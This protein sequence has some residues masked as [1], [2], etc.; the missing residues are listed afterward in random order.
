M[1]HE[2]R[3]I[4]SRLE[5]WGRWA[6]A[7][8]GPRVAACMTGV[9]CDAMQ[10]A[11]QGAP[12]PK[13]GDYI[14]RSIDSADAVLISRAMVRITLGHRRMLGLHYVDGKTDRYI[15][16]FL[17]F[18]PAEFDRR[19]L[20]AQAAVEHALFSAYQNSNSQQCLGINF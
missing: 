14:M 7:S 3:G 5:N 12:L 1:T 9:I 17:R 11:K 2:R 18:Q 20:E 8:D 6:N 10:K 16:A 19:M 4:E 15:A 13:T